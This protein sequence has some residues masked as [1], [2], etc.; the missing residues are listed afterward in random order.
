MA[1]AMYTGIWKEECGPE[2]LFAL[3]DY[4]NYS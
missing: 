1:V 4:L 3:K 2:N